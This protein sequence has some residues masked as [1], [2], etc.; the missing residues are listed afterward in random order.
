M[1]CNQQFPACPVFKQR[2][3]FKAL[4]KHPLRNTLTEELYGYPCQKNEACHS[5]S[6]YCVAAEKPIEKI[7]VKEIAERAEINKTTFIPTTKRWMRSPPK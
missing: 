3:T 7:T 2:F 1:G 4:V 5:E 6:V